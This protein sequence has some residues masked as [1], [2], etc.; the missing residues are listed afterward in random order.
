MIV[1]GKK[2][3]VC[4]SDNCKYSYQ[5]S[6]T[7]FIEEIVPR[8]SAADLITVYGIHRISDLGDGRSDGEG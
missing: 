1:D 5:N 6:E 3:V 8:S 4:K 7:P 2:Q